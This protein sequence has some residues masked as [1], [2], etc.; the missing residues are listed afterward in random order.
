MKRRASAPMAGFTVD[1]RDLHPSL[2]PFQRT[3]VTLALAPGTAP[4]C[5]R[6]L[7][8]GRAGKCLNGCAS[9]PRIP[10]AG[11]CCS[12]RWPWRTSSCATRRQRW[13]RAA[14]LPLQ[15][16]AEASARPLIVTNYDGRA[17]RPATFAGVALD[18]ADIIANFVGVN[19]TGC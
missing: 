11:V 1:E 15:A 18:E 5:S 3:A 13:A 9:W 17:L 8:L 12:C 7:A 14:L 10:A 19:S 2:F 4:H 16:E 6:T